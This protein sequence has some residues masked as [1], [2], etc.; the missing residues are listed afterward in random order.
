MPIFK[1]N[2]YV[3]HYAILVVHARNDD[4]DDM[5]LNTARWKDGLPQ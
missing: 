2:I 3:W 4:D 1:M 5:D